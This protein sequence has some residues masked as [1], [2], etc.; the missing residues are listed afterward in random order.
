[1]KKAAKISL[2]TVSVILVLAGIVICALRWKAWFGN[3]P[4]AK[5]D[6]PDYPHNI[7]LTYGEKAAI[8]RTVS[9]R[10][11][12][13]V[14]PSELQLLRWRQQDTLIFQA[15][16]DVI[17]S[18]MG[19]AAYYRV[20]L[21][22]L[23]AGNYSYRCCNPDFCSDWYSLYVPEHSGKQSMQ[24]F[25]VFGD[26]Q[27][28]KGEASAF[29]FD[30]AFFNFQLNSQNPA[31]AGM[32]FVGD[33]IERPANKYWQIFF[34]SL[35]GKQTEIPVIAATG[36]HEYLKG[37]HKVLD[38]RWTSIFGNPENGPERFSETTYFIDFP[39]CRIIVLDTDA[40]QLFSDYTV[41]QTWL[42]K[43][44]SERNNSWKIVVMHH[45]VYA[46]GKGRDNFA[47][48]WVF[49]QPLKKADVVLCGHD[50][51]Y[52]RKTDKSGK[53]VYILTNSSEKF[54]EPKAEIEADCYASNLR[55]YEDMK[56]YA[57]SLRIDTWNVE[58]DSIFDSVVLRK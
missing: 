10:A 27:D 48:R 24:E 15:E 14:Q 57:D 25:L 19:K 30:Q 34:S 8:S 31:L 54:Y 49:H 3:Q 38:T 21:D 39:N 50:H 4:E 36:N 44:L 22:S 23:A 56:V 6:V 29:M 43:V 51:N 13:E 37:M 20:I 18:R 28:K 26:V 2:I 47:I 11:G 16:G 17:K 42:R 7:V 33:I 12:E 58:T 52:M 1:M 32:I 45:P 46:A 9:W 55:F 40:L 53:P 35:N 5:Y 41:M